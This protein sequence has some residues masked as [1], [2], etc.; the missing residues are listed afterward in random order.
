MNIGKQ[1]DLM[2]RVLNRIKAFIPLGMI[3]YVHHRRMTLAVH[4]GI[5]DLS[6]NTRPSLLGGCKRLYSAR[7]VAHIF[8]LMMESIV[9]SVSVDAPCGKRSVL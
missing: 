9:T 4:T 8:G 7:G 2:I 6:P 3:L 5:S 1:L